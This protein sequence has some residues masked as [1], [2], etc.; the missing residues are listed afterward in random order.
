MMRSRAAAGIGALA[1][2]ALG[3]TGC[4]EEAPAEQRS[5]E[6]QSIGLMV[7]D[8]SNPFF[9]AMAEGVT[10]RA[11]ELG[12]SVNVQDGRQDLAAQNEQIDAFIQQGIDVLLLNAV[13]SEG[14]GPA[15]SRAKDAGMVVVAVDVTAKGADATVTLD[16]TE[17]GELACEYLAEEIG[18]SG[19][20]IIVDGRPISSIQDRV[21]GCDRA[22][23]RY[24]EIRVVA[25]QNGD[26][27]RALALDL[28][29]DMIT[30]NPGIVGIFGVN[31]PTALG[32][33]LAAQQAGFS[34]LV[35]VGVDASPEGVSE[36]EID[37]SMF[38]GTPAQDPNSQGSI[39]LDM[40]VSL[41]AG[42]TLEDDLVLVPTELITRENVAD[43]PG[44]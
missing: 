32:A 33:N 34:D 1:V 28:T 19:D 39:A 6:V 38:S 26:N 4:S 22:L 18:G 21:A 13:D 7:Q 36:L 5:G 35:I 27:G 16:N 42:E 25:Q 44:W 29:T 2:G 14:I 3:L 20:I 17:A 11:D 43:Y 9:Q 10:S 31:D 24:P 40:A 12:A 37:G 41:M 23:E 30:A 15:V 8:L